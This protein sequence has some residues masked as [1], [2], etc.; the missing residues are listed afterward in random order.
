MTS[1]ERYL[2][3]LET[4]IEEAEQKTTDAP[5]P[6]EEFFWRGVLFGLES[7]LGCGLPPVFVPA[8]KLDSELK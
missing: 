3:R 2:T 5:N 4:L 8:L 6:E 1:I 7:A